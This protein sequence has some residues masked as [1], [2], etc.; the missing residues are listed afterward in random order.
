VRNVRQRRQRNDHISITMSRKINN[1]ISRIN[2]LINSFSYEGDDE[3]IDTSLLEIENLLGQLHKGIDTSDTSIKES[4][5]N[6]SASFSKIKD[7]TNEKR[8]RKQLMQG[9]RF[10]SIF[11]FSSHSLVLLM[12]MMLLLK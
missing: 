9:F 5:A 4:F 1:M 8:M 6:L 10:L 2:F 11:T 3:E 7:R 12:G